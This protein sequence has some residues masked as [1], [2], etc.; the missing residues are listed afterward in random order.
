M[1]LYFRRTKLFYT[2]EKRTYEMQ[3]QYI[4]D[5]RGSPTTTEW[6]EFHEAFIKFNVT[7]GQKLV[8]L[9]ESFNKCSPDLQKVMEQLNDVA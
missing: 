1:F 7:M 2:K 4:F 3:L 5:V 8:D 9:H 6:P